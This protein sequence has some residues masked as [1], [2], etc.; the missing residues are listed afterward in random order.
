M[1]IVLLGTSVSCSLAESSTES[2]TIILLFCVPVQK[3][4][5]QTLQ[6]NFDLILL[7]PLFTLD[8]GARF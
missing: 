8:V 4:T 3:K 5:H 1:F 6:W 7:Y 2:T